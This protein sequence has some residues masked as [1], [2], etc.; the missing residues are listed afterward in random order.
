MRHPTVGFLAM[1]LRLVFW[2]KPGLCVIGA[3][4]MPEL[5]SFL[6]KTEIRPKPQ[7][8]QRSAD[9]VC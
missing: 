9:K 4:C 8:F 6:A 2:S 5:V 1:L 7:S 3:E